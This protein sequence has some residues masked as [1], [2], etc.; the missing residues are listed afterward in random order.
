MTTFVGVTGGNSTG[1]IDG[2]SSVATFN[3]PIGIGISTENNIFITE[4]YSQ[5]IRKISPAGKARPL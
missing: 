2:S 5:T 1:Y 3:Y 4:Y